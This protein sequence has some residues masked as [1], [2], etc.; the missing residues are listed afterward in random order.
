MKVGIFLLMTV[1][2]LIVSPGN[3]IPDKEVHKLFTVLSPEQTHIDFNNKLVDTEEHSILLYSNYFGGGGVGVGDINND[4]LH[5]LFFAGNLVG[6]RLYLNKGDM[7]F[8]NITIS[9]GIE[10][11]GGW[12]SGVLMDDVDGDGF[13]DIY[14]TRELYD[15]KPELRRNKFYKNN[16]DN[17]FTECAEVYGIDDNQRTRHATF[18][19][20]DRD[21]DLDLFLLNQPPNPG[22]YSEFLDTELL[23][24][25]FT[26]RLYENQGNIFIDVTKKAGLFRTGFPNSVT[27]SD[28]NGDGW[29][30]LYIA[31]DYWVGDFMYINNGDGTFTDKIDEAIRHITFS[32]MGV[33][34]GDLNND[35]ALDI[36][37]LD[38]VPE[39]YYRLKT[40]L[41]GMNAKAFWKVVNEGGHYQ[42]FTN[43]LQLNIGNNQYS[44]IVQLAGLPSTDW[45][46]SEFIADLDNDGWK[47][48]FIANG[49]LRDIRDHDASIEY[50]QVI[51]NAIHEY[52]MENPNPV[53]ISI[54]DI[55]NMDSV[56]NIAPSEKLSNYV[57][58][59]NRD[60]TFSKM[61]TDWGMELKTFS[62]GCAYG[63][64]DND[65]DLDI[66]VNNIND[67][68]T[69]YRNNA[70]QLSIGH[71]L[72]VIPIADDENI[73][74]PGTRV[75]VETD[76]GKQFFE[77]TGVR[78]MYS[79]SE[80]VA[81]FG[82]G[83]IEKADKVIVQWQ[84][85][86]KNILKNVKVDQTI[87]VK[88]SKSK[89]SEPVADPGIHST[90]FMEV[91][92]EMGFAIKHRE[93][94]FDDYQTQVLLPHKMSN[95]GPCIATGDINGD[96]LHDF[97]VGGATL[98]PGYLMVQ[99]P[100]G[101]FTNR[102]AGVLIEDRIHEDMGAAF[103]DADGDNDIDL[104]VVS[105]GNEFRPNAK[106]YQD[107]L[108]LND[109]EGNFLKSVD[110]LPEL[111]ISGS[112][113]L[114]EDFD[115]DGDMDLFVAGRHVPW[116]YPQPA[117]S[118]LLRNDEGKFLD[119]TAQVATDLID[120]GMVNDAT[121][122]DFNGD[123]LK[124]LALVGEWMPVTLLQSDGE[125]FRNVTSENGLSETTGWW[126][127]V[128]S[129]DMDRDGDMDFV[130]GNLG[131]NY[132]Y[133]ASREEPFEVYSYDFD[134][135]GR[136]DIVLSY[137][138]NGRK[139]P[140]RRRGCSIDQVPSL[141]EKFPTYAEF[142]SAD[143][144]EIYDK[145]YLEK[146]LHY[147]A[148]TFAS[149]YIENLGNGSFQLHQ[150]PV[151]T[152]LSSVNDILLLD[153]NQDNNLDILLA[154]NLYASE[155]RTPRNDAGYGL[156][157]MGDGRGGFTST[158]P[159]E[160]G[161]FV[162]YDVKSMSILQAQNSKMILVGCNNDFL[163]IFQVNK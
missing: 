107:R 16:G 99:Q 70:T 91:T 133:K 45:S 108:Y 81:H 121:W 87:E 38:M 145:S 22:N 92:R 76:A 41:G 37:V 82:F 51:N 69:I 3:D 61:T 26:T 8:E 14:V 157:L 6:D 147:K 55:M 143:V 130:A 32:S 103:F 64:L 115:G 156:Y 93:N 53:D 2:G 90:P 109:G 27:A 113:V 155:V 60:L 62:N 59:N 29:T 39:D 126:F 142:A 98:F 135:N 80:Q 140:W 7:V 54:W 112:R 71:Y 67:P 104:Y 17:T 118:V 58:K 47:D 31:N 63:D 56:L 74:R 24:D 85:G 110:I 94:E 106:E 114:P 77:I 20:Y 48:I 73:V 111:R 137:F 163:R 40:N 33:D 124:D 131:L 1:L 30:D 149:S 52:I 50:V 96:N 25:E 129:A 146:A 84:D 66:I 141:K 83:E 162:P 75:W 150:L 154:G 122:T 13:I 148:Y 132:K 43:T 117:T 4:G 34:A 79:S 5:D 65:G 139:Y 9:A 18:I 35:G 28:L 102:S 36:L 46:W 23:L 152:Q 128:E 19:D 159:E 158:S 95:F 97:F 134:N 101:T 68:A 153:F 89:S 105:G 161:F 12:S 44:E 100:D 11:N 21:G 160:S 78:G 138:Q 15:K 10:D 151:E 127:S 125:K 119:V 57:Y 144:F 88:Y 136:Q 49:L 123:G 42:Y 116:S 120:I 86:R 72:R